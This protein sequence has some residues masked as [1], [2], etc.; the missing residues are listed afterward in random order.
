M[1]RVVTP[2]LASIIFGFTAPI[3]AKSCADREL[4]SGDGKVRLK[5]D[6]VSFDR[7]LWCFIRG[8][9][10]SGVRQGSGFSLPPMQQSGFD[11]PTPKAQQFKK[12]SGILCTRDLD[13][14]VL[15]KATFE[16]RTIL[17]ED[18]WIDGSPYRQSRWVTEEI[19]A[20]SNSV[21]GSVNKNWRGADTLDSF[22]DERYS[23][24]FEIGNEFNGETEFKLRNDCE[25]D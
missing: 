22:N 11:S 3:S 13:S 20:N 2:L 18:R 25:R 24:G 19:Y 6:A 17:I 5:V 1:K 14:T 8:E 21:K 7:H 23:V 10:V 4:V 12:S 16:E 15:I 9:G